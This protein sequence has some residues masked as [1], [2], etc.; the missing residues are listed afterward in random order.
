VD[1]VEIPLRDRPLHVPFQPV[2]VRAV[3]PG[4][5]RDGAVDPGVGGRLCRDPFRLGQHRRLLRLWVKR[6]RLVDPRA[7]VVAVHAGAG[8]VDEPIRRGRAVGVR[9]DR[10]PESVDEH[11]P[12]RLRPAPAAAGGE[13][14]R[15]GVRQRGQFGWLGHVRRDGVDSRLPDGLGGA[16]NAGHVVARGVELA[17][18]RQPDV[19]RTDDCHPHG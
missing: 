19:A 7:V 18:Q 13:H 3:Q 11:A 9:V 14:D 8:G 10:V 2:A 17:T 6:G 16:P 12:C 1:H 4:E 15:V 5:P